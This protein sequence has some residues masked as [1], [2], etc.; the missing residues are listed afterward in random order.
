MAHYKAET[1]SWT[2]NILVCIVVVTVMCKRLFAYWFILLCW[3]SQSLVRVLSDLILTWDVWPYS[4]AYWALFLSSEGNLLLDV[5]ENERRIKA[6]SWKDR[7]FRNIFSRLLS[8]A[9]TLRVYM[10]VC[11]REN[12]QHFQFLP[13]ASFEKLPDLLSVCPC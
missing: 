6:V 7:D 13:V 2:I 8:T 9:V 4:P 5:V 3:Q 1:C 10:C 12:K 11:E